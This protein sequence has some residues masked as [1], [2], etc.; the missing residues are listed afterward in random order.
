MSLTLKLNVLKLH[1]IIKYPYEILNL[2]WF[3]EFYFLSKNK[4][5]SKDGKFKQALYKK[6][7]PIM[8]LS[9]KQNNQVKVFKKLLL[10]HNPSIN[11]FSRK[12]P[13]SQL[14][15]LLDQG[16]QTGKFLSPVLKALQTHPVFDIGSGN[17]FPGLL[18]SVLY[19]NN[20]FYLCERNRKKAEF[21]KWV[22]N[23]ADIANAEVLC[24]NAEDIKK[25]FKIILSQAA[26][27]LKEMLS[28]LGKLLSQDGQAFLW[29]SPS[30][31]IEWPKD[32]VF[33]PEVFKSYNLGTVE[34]VLLKL[35][36]P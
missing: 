29:K 27:P 5:Y 31:K 33:T 2:I 11:L 36:K 22:L 14:K 23:K 6:I 17:G 10:E 35:K 7:L 4:S 13:D 21:L 32:S 26:M 19:S 18:F 8:K 3:G 28:L 34:Q 25:I 20:Y 15:F 1:S 30:W 9:Q 16:F 24:Q 12:N